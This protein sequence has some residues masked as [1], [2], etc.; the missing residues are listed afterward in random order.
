[1]TIGCKVQMVI[2][3]E[4]RTGTIVGLEKIGDGKQKHDDVVREPSIS[5]YGDAKESREVEHFQVAIDDDGR[6]EVD[7]KNRKGKA[8]DNKPKGKHA[9]KVI[10]KFPC[11]E[12]RRRCVFESKGRMARVG[13]TEFVLYSTVAVSVLDV[14]DASAALSYEAPISGVA[15]MSA[16]AS[17]CAGMYGIF[18][19]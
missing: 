12:L 6:D 3:N 19:Q 15:C 2:G 11:T 4:A 10:K 7:E 17:I 13:L 9:G 1:M 14:L 18:G 5:S 8:D 16:M